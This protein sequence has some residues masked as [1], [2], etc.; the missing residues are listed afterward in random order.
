MKIAVATLGER[1][2]DRDVRK[3][4]ASIATHLWHKGASLL[5]VGIKEVRGQFEK[6]SAVSVLNS[7]GELIARG[8]V[9][10]TSSELMEIMGKNSEQIKQVLGYHGSDEVVHRDNLV[11][12]QE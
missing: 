2:S 8:L 5:P 6:G 11:L 3:S 12:L 4:L 9:N 7:E 10:Y 1:F